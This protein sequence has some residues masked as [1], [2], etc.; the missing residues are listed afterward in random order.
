MK[1]NRFSR[2]GL[3]ALRLRL[4]SHLW[5]LLLLLL[6]RLLWWLLV[7]MVLL[8]HRLPDLLWRTPNRLLRDNHDLRTH[9][10]VVLGRVDAGSNEQDEVNQPQETS[11]DGSGGEY[12]SPAVETVT[13]LN[14][15]LLT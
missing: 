5:L 9:S 2:R 8:R 13:A 7:V 4:R 10:S 6:L 11:K 1:R 12:V 15:I 3:L 14:I